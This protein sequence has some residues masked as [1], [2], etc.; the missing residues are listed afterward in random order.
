M[1]ELPALDAT[2]TPEESALAQALI[3]RERADLRRGFWVVALIFLIS[4]S[5]AGG[6][7]FLVFHRVAAL[8]LAVG[9]IILLV[10]IRLGI[11]LLRLGRSGNVVREY[12]RTGRLNDGRPALIVAREMLATHAPS[13]PPLL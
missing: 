6:I 12:W 9:G 8:G 1:S 10:I 4:S 5:C 2:A 11:R 13:T 3:E 7:S